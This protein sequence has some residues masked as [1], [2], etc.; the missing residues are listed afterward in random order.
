MV[1]RCVVKKEGV[2]LLDGIHA[3]ERTRDWVGNQRERERVTEGR[4]GKG[5]EEKEKVEG[6]SCVHMGEIII[7]HS[8]NNQRTRPA[9]P[10]RYKRQ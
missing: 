7:T 5:R 4:T 10:L 3:E 8:Q 1:E 2:L 6:R 9:R